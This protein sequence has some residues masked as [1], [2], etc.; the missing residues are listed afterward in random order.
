MT[1]NFWIF[2]ATNLL[3]FFDFR[4]VWPVVFYLRLH[5]G[6]LQ[7]LHIIYSKLHSKLCANLSQLCAIIC[8]ACRGDLQSPVVQCCTGGIDAALFLAIYSKLKRYL[9]KGRFFRLALGLFATPFFVT[10]M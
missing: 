6:V 9:V 5:V 10:K 8:L 3:T 2:W 4:T 1:D 7:Y